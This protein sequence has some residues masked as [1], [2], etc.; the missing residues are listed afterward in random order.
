MVH[1]FFK[2]TGVEGF[3]HICT[4]IMMQRFTAFLVL[5]LGTAALKSQTKQED[6]GQF[7]GNLLLNYQKY[8]RDDRI[9]ANTRVYLENTASVD[10]WLFMQ[11]RRNGYNFTMRFDAFNNSPLLDPQSAYTDHGIGFWQASKQLKDLNITVGSFYD[12]F[13]SGVL[14]RAYEQR[15][16]GLDYSI[17]GVRL[18]YDINDDWRLK[19]FSGNQKGNQNSGT[20]FSYTPQVISG[21]NLEGRV[22]IGENAKF[23]GLNLGA[24]ALNRNIDRATMQELVSIVQSYEEKDWF[25]PKYN[26]YGF[27]GYFNYDIG[28]FSIGGEANYKTPEAILDFNNKLILKDGKVFY[29][30]LG[31]GK[32]FKFGKR[33]LTNGRTVP[34]RV[35]FGLNLQLRHVDYFP[36]RTSPREGLL[37]GLISYLPSLTKQNSYRLMARYN[38]PAQD[39]GEN[40]IQGELTCKINRGTRILANAS[41]VQS[42][43]SN[44]MFDSSSMSM[45]PIQLF[46]EYNVQLIQ[47]IGKDKL[48][49]GLQSIFYNQARYEQEPEYDDVY[50]IT[51]FAEWLHKIGKDKSLRIEAQYLNTDR[52]QGSFAN[53][54]V[55]YYFN[56]E[57]S[58]SIGDMVNVQP[59]RYDRMIIEDAVLHYPMFFFSYNHNNSFY[60]LSYLKQQE[61]VNCSGGICRVEPAFSGI[62]FTV[63]SNF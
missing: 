28:N 1:S 12:Q 15:Q 34:N 52:D 30:T 5:L 47:N 62:R 32:R 20:R 39:L 21:I 25:F 45:K 61:G 44:G 16:L 51:P 58:M 37:N 26:V 3:L 57:W 48:K 50:T 14:F 55:E 49:L 17:Q 46:R 23:G 59:H 29:G 19:A 9:G 41:Y 38:A 4:I 60:T 13:G 24:S 42:L 53:V 11:Y 56:K 27:N 10:A 7:S 2:S 18:I 35:S 54:L 8:V 33:K 22:N 63:S 31:W 36:L 40:G 6:K 43:A